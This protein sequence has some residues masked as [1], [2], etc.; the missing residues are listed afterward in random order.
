MSEGSPIGLMMVGRHFDDATVLRAGH[1][2]Q[3]ATAN[4]ADGARLGV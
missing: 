3:R 1:A 2:Y 4:H